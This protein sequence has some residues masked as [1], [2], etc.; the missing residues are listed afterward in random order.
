MKGS[1]WQMADAI[2]NSNSN[3]DDTQEVE[4]EGKKCVNKLL[5]N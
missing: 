2:A 5:E 1:K 4:K 3:N